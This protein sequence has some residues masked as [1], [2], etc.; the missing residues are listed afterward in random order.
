MVGGAA[1]SHCDL[2][3]IIPYSSV[4][5]ASEDDDKITAH[6]D[7]RRPHPV[8]VDDKLSSSPDRQDAIRMLIG[9][10]EHLVPDNGEQSKLSADDDRSSPGSGVSR[11]VVLG[12]VYF[13]VFDPWSVIQEYFIFFGLLLF[14]AGSWRS[15]LILDSMLFHPMLDL[16][17][18]HWFYFSLYPVVILFLSCHE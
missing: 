11:H 18:L 12:E 15:F 3:S 6:G 7:P 17:V 5:T 10:L 2:V 13:M 16:L 1:V 14:L 9:Y 4:A 8:A